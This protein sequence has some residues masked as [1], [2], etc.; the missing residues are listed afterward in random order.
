MTSHVPT[1]SLPVPRCPLSILQ[2]LS[3]LLDAC[4]VPMG[5]SVASAALSPLAAASRC[6]VHAVVML[7]MLP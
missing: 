4:M 7:C 6:A 1:Q 5:N 2:G 3:Q